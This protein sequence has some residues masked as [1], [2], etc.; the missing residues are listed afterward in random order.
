MDFQIYGVEIKSVFEICQ[1]GKL[2]VIYIF[3]GKRFIIFIL[4]RI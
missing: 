3:F 2:I 4:K 1:L